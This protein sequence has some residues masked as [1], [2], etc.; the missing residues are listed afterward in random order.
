VTIL[1]PVSNVVADFEGWLT[2]EGGV[3]NIKI[4]LRYQAQSL[5]LTFRLYGI[6]SVITSDYKWTS[7]YMRCLGKC[8]RTL[9]VFAQLLVDHSSVTLQLPPKHLPSSFD[10]STK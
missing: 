7:K 6:D 4:G 9:S 8:K 3:V 2:F 10:Q 1:L 5:T